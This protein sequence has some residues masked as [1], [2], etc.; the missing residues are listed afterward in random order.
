MSSVPIS[1]SD[2]YNRLQ[3][4]PTLSETRR[5]SLL[6][7]KFADPIKCEL[8]LVD[9]GENPDFEALSYVWGDPA[10]PKQTIF[11]NGI[12][13]EVTTNL[14]TALRR[15]R[16]PDRIRYLWV[17]ALSINQADKDE[18]NE[19]VAYMRTIYQKTS[20]ALIW[21]GDSIHNTTSEEQEVAW[22]TDFTR[23]HPVDPMTGDVAV[24]PDDA[25]RIEDYKNEFLH[26]YRTPIAWRHNLTQDFE[27]GAFCLIHLLAQNKHLNDADIP[28]F[29]AH[30]VRQNVVRVLHKIMETPWWNRQWVIQETVLP[31]SVS[32]YYGR[33]KASWEMFSVAAKNYKVHRQGCCSSQ[34]AQ[35]PV[36]IV[37]GITHFAE[38]VHGLDD[39]RQSWNEADN[40]H[41][42]LRRLLWQFRDRETTNPK[43]N[44]Y[45]LLPLV[46]WGTALQV[47]ANYRWNIAA[48]YR[49]VAVKIFDVD[50]SLLILMGTTD[51]SS[52]LSDPYNPN[53]PK[54]SELLPTWVP[55]WT[56]KPP[57][58]EL[59][60]Q[61][62]AELYNASLMNNN[63]RKTSFYATIKQRYLQLKG[64]QL[65][66][67]TDVGDMMPADDI[68]A[69]LVFKQWQMLSGMDSSSSPRY[70]DG[71]SLGQA[72]WK[73]LCMNTKHLDKVNDDDNLHINKSD[74]E[75]T[76]R[77]YGQEFDTVW[78][79][80]STQSGRG[81]DSS[82]PQ[83]ISPLSRQGRTQTFPQFDINTPQPSTPTRSGLS[84]RHRQ[85]P[86]STTFIDRQRNEAV[87]IDESVH[88]ATTGQCFFRTMNGYMGLGPR[89]MESGDVVFVFQRGHTPFLLR[90]NGQEEVPGKGS[91]A[92]WGLVGDCYVQGVMA[93]EAVGD[94][95]VW[96]EVYLV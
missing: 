56:V 16:L 7:G 32:V 81:G 17:D 76:D 2:L 12:N 66:V 74:Y 13:H 82:D 38:T 46:N 71:D 84:L 67:V 49:D 14:F 4:D 1:A 41:I 58:Y 11:L 62:R 85:S 30:V 60:R 65:D 26:Y 15:F 34:Y 53:S 70:I 39:W 95:R 20:R 18:R 75:L 86:P 28:F 51:K 93:G 43:D 73:T 31:P 94:G 52:T 25:K 9:L 61:L 5:V 88:S 78:S 33:Y 45:A 80:R 63:G 54:L 37:R 91:K 64:F 48:V 23:N 27:L 72:Y 89:K 59:A 69:A 44:V 79:R 68:S 8:E 29:L 19:Q 40:S 3:V 47:K 36:E 22:N 90:S 96:D 50:Q 87:A 55:D 92:V 57:T 42:G 21:L 6:P 24:D 35:L 10:G 83:A 77:D